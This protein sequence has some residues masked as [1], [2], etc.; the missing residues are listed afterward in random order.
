MTENDICQ[1]LNKMELDETLNTKSSHLKVQAAQIKLL[2]FQEWHLTYLLEHPKINPQNY[3]TNL[4]VM[5]K[6]RP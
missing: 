3:L 5:I 6:V 1:A 2:S 4:R